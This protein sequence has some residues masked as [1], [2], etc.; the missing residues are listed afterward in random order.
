MKRY[1]LRRCGWWF[2]ASVLLTTCMPGWA[3]APAERAARLAAHYNLDKPE[4]NGPFPAVMLVPACNGFNPRLMKE[5]RYKN[6]TRRLKELGF[7]VIRVDYLAAGEVNACDSIIYPAELADDIVTVTKYL[8]AQSF[9]KPDA[10]NVLAWSYG[11]GAAFNALTKTES[12]EPA[13]VA[14]VVAYY[15][16][17]AL[18]RPW[19][20][21]VPALVFCGDEDTV[22]PCARFES[23]LDEVPTRARV[24]VVKYPESYHVFDNSELPT[25]VTSVS[26]STIGYNE[27][28]ATA[29]WAEVEKFLRR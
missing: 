11:G 28:S 25:K 29:A 18:A 24:K 16:Y 7:A 6:A 17:L 12:R 21:D 15:P 20:V 27:K 10:I 5:G 1:F 26:G 9:V 22:A 4:G 23:L 13:Q 14:A 8:R 19:S 3:D 2:L